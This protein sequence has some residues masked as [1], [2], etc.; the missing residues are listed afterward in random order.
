[1]LNELRENC[2]EAYTGIVQGLKGDAEVP[3]PEV[4]LI[5]QHIQYMVHFVLTI[6]NDPEIT[7]SLI[8]A[9]A[10]LL[11][12][13]CAAFGPGLLAL[14]ENEPIH[15]ML[16]KG[17]KSKNTKT[18]TLSGWAIKEIRKLRAPAGVVGVTAGL[19]NNV[20]GATASESW[21]VSRSVD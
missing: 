13:L 20:I 17:K 5:Q 18:R 14:V 7:D 21:S 15:V 10:G 1:Y 3:N 16:T 9:C 19:V 12:D 8:A 11:G 6:A 4:Q 2:L